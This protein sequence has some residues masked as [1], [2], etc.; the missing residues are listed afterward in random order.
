VLTELYLWIQFSVI[1][2]F[3]VYTMVRRGPHV[4]EARKGK[5]QQ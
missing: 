4:L 2:L 3:F 5:G 1:I